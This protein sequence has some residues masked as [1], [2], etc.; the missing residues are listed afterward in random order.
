MNPCRPE[1]GIWV[2]SLKEKLR[3]RWKETASAL[4]AGKDDPHPLVLT[5]HAVDNLPKLDDTTRGD[6]APPMRRKTKHE[7]RT[8]KA[9]PVY[10][11]LLRGS[12]RRT[13]AEVKLV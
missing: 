6:V 11:P 4:A 9:S 2:N 13:A 1:H 7:V 8:T 3:P 10:Y 12:R 5:E